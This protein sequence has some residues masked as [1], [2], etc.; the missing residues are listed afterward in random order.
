[1]LYGLAIIAMIMGGYESGLSG[2]RR[3]ISMTFL[4]A[5][6]FSVVLTLTLALD[7]PW[8]HLSAVTLES[9]IDVQEDIR[10]SMQL[11]N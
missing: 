7:R 1:M 3:V 9:M 6:S 10:R 5:L 11:E 2:N 4:A 8:Q